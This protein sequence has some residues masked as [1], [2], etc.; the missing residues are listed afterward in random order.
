MG[1]RA[2]LASGNMN[3]PLKPS[4]TLY[5]FDLK[6]LYLSRNVRWSTMSE[7][8][9][10]VVLLALVTTAPL[11]AVAQTDS[12]VVQPA[13]GETLICQIIESA[14][15]DNALPVDF[16]AKL[17]WQESRFRPDEVGPLTR[18]GHRAQ[19]IA[20]FMPDTAVDR[21]LFEPL[22]PVVALPKSGKFLAEL[23]DEFGN[24]GLA[25]A[26]YNAGPQRVR[27]FISGL[28]NLPAETRNYVLA[29]TGRPIENW[30]QQGKTSLRRMQQE[31]VTGCS[32]YQQ[33][34]LS[35][36]RNVSQS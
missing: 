22:N 26:A 30:M 6:G 33:R 34:E 11:R 25:A 14:A 1:R 3:R 4:F 7:F 9:L 31:C 27:E 21:Q 28:R 15:H 36:D 29:I 2:A 24:L 8:R 12:S 5:P 20:Q 23:R 13:S 10:L 16:F 18:T 32:R 17:I 19:G 35:R